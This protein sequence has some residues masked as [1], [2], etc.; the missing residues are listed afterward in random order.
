MAIGKVYRQWAS[1][2]AVLLQ[3]R[4]A[5]LIKESMQR[6]EYS[7]GIEGQLVKIEP[8]MVSFTISL[9]KDVYAA[10]FS[11]GEL[12]LDFEVTREIEAEGFS[13]E[14]IRRVQQTRKDMKLDVEEFVK[15]EVLADTKFAEYVKMWKEHIMSEVRSK[16]MELVMEVARRAGRQVGDRRGE[17]G[18]RG[19]L[20]EPEGFHKGAGQDPGHDRQGRR[21]TG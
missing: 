12:Y 19:L 8:N 15:V 5:A 4:P 13:R 3:S 17:G 18:D 10:T 2:I 20:H 9:P 14:I 6:G 7:L 1:K 11:G 21:G 16:S